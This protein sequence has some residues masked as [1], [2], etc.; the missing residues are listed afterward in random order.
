MRTLEHDFCYVYS[1][2]GAMNLFDREGEFMYNKIEETYVCHVEDA[3][4]YWGQ[5]FNRICELLTISKSFATVSHFMSPVFRNPNL[6]KVWGEMI[7]AD[8]C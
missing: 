1:V 7:S 5:S 6:H 2:S 3:V 4:M 8:K